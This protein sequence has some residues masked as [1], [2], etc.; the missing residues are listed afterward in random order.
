MVLLFLL[1]SLFGVDLTCAPY[2]NSRQRSAGGLPRLGFDT[3]RGQI[4]F[5]VNILGN[6]FAL[7]Q[8][9]Y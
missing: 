6:I 9:H 4:V 7:G 8:E 1:V 2:N 5:S 3:G